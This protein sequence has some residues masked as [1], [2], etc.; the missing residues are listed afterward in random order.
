MTR[1]PVEDEVLGSVQWDEEGE[2]W[3]ANAEVTPGRFNLVLLCSDA[4]AE[5]LSDLLCQARQ[6]FRWVR[7]HEAVCRQY[8]A[9]MLVGRT[10]EAV[11]FPVGDRETFLWLL[12]PEIFYLFA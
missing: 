1:V 5:Q 9:D 4:P 6:A 7:D 10:S 3:L 8:A 2:H 12:D 11:H